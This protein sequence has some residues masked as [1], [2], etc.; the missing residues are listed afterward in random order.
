MNPDELKKT[1]HEVVNQ[2]VDALVAIRSD[3]K[4]KKD[5]LKGKEESTS[6]DE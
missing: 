3:L 4:K 2:Q 1:L 5:A 6:I